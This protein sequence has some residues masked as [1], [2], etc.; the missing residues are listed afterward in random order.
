MKLRYHG[1]M[2]EGVVVPDIGDQV[3]EPGKSIEVPDD[4]AKNLLDQPDNWSSAEPKAK[5]DTASNKDG[6]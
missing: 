4:I 6:E 5:A 3:I 2:T 1:P